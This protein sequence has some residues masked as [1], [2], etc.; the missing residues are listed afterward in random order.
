MS[1]SEKWTR[2]CETILREEGFAKPRLMF[3]KFGRIRVS[4][5]QEGAGGMRGGFFSD[6]WRAGIKKENT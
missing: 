6:F 1:R 2:F 5:P 3:L 4:A